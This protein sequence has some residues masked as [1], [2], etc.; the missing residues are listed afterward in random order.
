[1][2]INK[3]VNELIE[4]ISR[5]SSGG[6]MFSTN[7]VTTTGGGEQ[8][9]I[10]WTMS[11]G[12]WE[13]G[14]RILNQTELNT[15]LDF[16]QEAAGKANSFR[17]KDFG[18]YVCNPGR[19]FAKYT[20]R[21]VQLVKRYG[22]TD[23]SRDRIIT[24]PINPH[25]TYGGQVVELELDDRGVVSIKDFEDDIDPDELL[26]SGEFDVRVRFDTDQL[27]HQFLG[28]DLEDGRAAFQLFSL[29]VVE[30]L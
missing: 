9:N 10:N 4:T 6:P 16:F 17:F 1:M 5:D 24:L 12:R 27:N 28:A 8:R 2:F 26:W 22:D 7:I 13:F 20:H 30:L 11:R 14:E 25:A 23:A 19:G 21:G 15:L 18:D 3:R 29:P